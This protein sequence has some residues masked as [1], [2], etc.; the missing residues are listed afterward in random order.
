MRFG[1][2]AEESEYI[3]TPE[4]LLEDMID[5]Y[6]MAIKS[7]AL[8]KMRQGLLSKEDFLKDAR[9][10]LEKNYSPLEQVVTETMNL[11]E[12]YVFGYHRLTELIQDKDITDIRCVSYDNIRIKTNGKRMS[13]NVMFKSPEDY[14][15]FVQFIGVRN[16]VDLSNYNALQRFTDIHS[17]EDFVLRFTVSMPL[18]NTYGE[19][20]VTIRKVPKDFLEIEEL[21]RKD[22]MSKEV[23][24]LLQAR[25][26]TGSML[27]SGGNSSGKTTLLN[28][29]KETL[30]D[31][32]A[33]LVSQQADELRSKYHPDTMFLHSLPPTTE[34]DVSYDLEEISI[35]GL[36]MDVDYFIIGEI[37]GREALYSLN[38]AY[39]GQLCAATIHAPS[40]D[41]ASE[42]FVD[43]AL[44]DSRYSRKELMKMMMCF[45]T[46]VFM[47][48]FKVAQ[49]FGAP[50]WDTE[51]EVIRYQVLYEREGWDRGPWFS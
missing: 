48:N 32:M 3:A 49:I 38:A 50:E 18:L 15:R 1:R 7:A 19:P 13:S 43:Y 34:S 39:T 37:K 29:L 25:F 41:K 51:E 6:S 22:M 31:D 46:I 11:F 35:A 47:K 24:E 4:E 9:L 42:K 33:V 40:A 14:R 5:D 17:S 36:T 30:P 12:R 21:I 20:Y 16:Q 10:H 2:K 27:I 28:A 26:R 23:A 8:I 45:Q 44:Q